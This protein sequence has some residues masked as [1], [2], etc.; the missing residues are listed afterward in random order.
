MS[1]IIM[2]IDPASFK[3]MG[4]CVALS[5]KQN[6]M[7]IIE[8][9][10]FVFDVDKDTK[11]NRFED[12]YFRVENIIKKYNVQYIAFERT[13]FGKPFV[14]SQIYETIGVIK[15]LAQKYGVK[16]VEISPMTAK[17]VITGSGKAKKTEMMKRVNEIFGLSK[18]DLSS[19]HEADAVAM[20]YYQHRMIQDEN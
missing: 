13:Q 12:L 4:I 6:D 19:D 7:K 3:N 15:Y 8:R 9:T 1:T 2:G 17:K 14:M 20:A 11:D 5:E 16:L 18:K 10:T